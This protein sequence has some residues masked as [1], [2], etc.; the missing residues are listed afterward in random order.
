MDENTQ[1]AAAADAP[2]SQDSGAPPEL[3]VSETIQLQDSVIDVLRTCYDPEIPVNIYELGL[4]YEIKVERSGAVYI[5][6]TLTAPTCPVAGSLP[7]EVETKV[8]ELP[9][10]SGAKVDVVWDPP[11][12][13]SKMS[14]AAKLQLGMW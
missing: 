4:I 14:E 10:V 8:K 6:M 11:W 3:S 1:A 5:R 9:G 12:D 2:A 13:M 7:P